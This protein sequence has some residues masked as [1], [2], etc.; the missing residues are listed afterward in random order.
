M[1]N[2]PHV[3]IFQLF[4][5]TVFAMATTEHNKK[6]KLSEAEKDCESSDS[7]SNENATTDSEEYVHIVKFS[8][9]EP[10]EGR[11]YLI[12]VS[13]IQKLPKD[14]MGIMKDINWFHREDMTEGRAKK[15][16]YGEEKMSYIE[17][18]L[19]EVDG[20][21][22]EDSHEDSDFFEGIPDMDEFEDYFEHKNKL[23]SSK[24]MCFQFPENMK[25]S[26]VFHYNATAI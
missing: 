25:P 7:V 6:R 5:I 4:F 12:P 18:L 20:K 15:I 16:G 2:C 13:L 8:G 23:D 22:I 14:V 9:T 24:K 3:T 11:N 1:S 21:E 17:L 26:F 19:G 10:G